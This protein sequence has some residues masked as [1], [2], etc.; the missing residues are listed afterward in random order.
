MGPWVV[1]VACRAWHLDLWGPGLPEEVVD[2]C[3][4]L[5]LEVLDQGDLVFLVGLKVAPSAQEDP[6]DQASGR[7]LGEPYGQGAGP[8]PLE[9]EVL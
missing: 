8:S 3:L 4:C 2:P 1:G 5:G 6:C 7:V 9:E